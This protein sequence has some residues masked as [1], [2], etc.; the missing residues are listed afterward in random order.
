MHLPIVWLLLSQ[1]MQILLS[2]SCFVGTQH[3]FVVCD[4]DLHLVQ[5]VSCWQ[6]FLKWSMPPQAEQWICGLPV[7]LG[8]MCELVP[9]CCCLDWASCD[10]FFLTP[11][12][13]FSW[14]DT[15][16]NEST[17]FALPLLCMGSELLKFDP[18]TF[19]CVKVG[20][21]STCRVWWGYIPNCRY[22]T[23]VWQAEP[24]ICQLIHISQSWI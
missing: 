8:E 17:I 14:S 20:I 21:P 7:F 16:A 22:G 1:Y 24:H 10:D 11:F 12:V 23:V 15:P 4:L 3:I 2:I 6:S 18:P 19:L 5:K 9:D 13:C